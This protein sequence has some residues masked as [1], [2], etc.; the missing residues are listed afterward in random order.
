MLSDLFGTTCIAEKRCDVSWH[1]KVPFAER[2]NQESIA[3]IHATGGE[4]LDF[5]VHAVSSIITIFFLGALC[6]VL[7]LSFLQL[8]INLPVS[9]LSNNISSFLMFDLAL[10]RISLAPFFGR[11]AV[12]AVSTLQNSHRCASVDSN[13]NVFDDDHP[14]QLR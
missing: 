5:P 13:T 4:A 3:Y 6:R 9:S 12:L 8:P 7:C 2:S 10:R 11:E 14:A 1:H